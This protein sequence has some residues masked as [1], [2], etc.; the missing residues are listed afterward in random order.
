MSRSVWIVNRTGWDYDDNYYYKTEGLTPYQAFTDLE[1]AKSFMRDLEARE[2]RDCASRFFI[3]FARLEDF[4]NSIDSTI[5]E[6][7]ES[8][9]LSYDGKDVTFSK[10][11]ENYSDDELINIAQ[12]FFIDFFQIVEVE[13]VA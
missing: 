10:P 5:E 1:L 8:L 7:C 11:V 13:L 6:V 9:S 4:D 2:I 12:A 3:D